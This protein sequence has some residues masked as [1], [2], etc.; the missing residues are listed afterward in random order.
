MYLSQQFIAMIDAKQVEFNSHL[1]SGDRQQA[2]H[3]MGEKEL[4][5][6]W[7][8][9]GGSGWLGGIQ[10]SV[11]IYIRPIVLCRQLTKMGLPRMNHA[12]LV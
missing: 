6:G 4:M 10:N 12:C 5:S 1:G 11:K 9:E 3:W 7:G 2:R 8:W